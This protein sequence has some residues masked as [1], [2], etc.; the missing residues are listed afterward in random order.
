MG[1]QVADYKW[2]IKASNL[3]ERLLMKLTISAK[4]Y[5]PSWVQFPDDFRPVSLASQKLTE[6]MQQRA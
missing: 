2:Q 6:R 5:I 4:V 1:S 3:R